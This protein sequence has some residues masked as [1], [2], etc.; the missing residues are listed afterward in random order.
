MPMSDDKKIICI[1]VDGVVLNWEDAFQVWMK[2]QG[3]EQVEGH[4]FIYDAAKQF[5]LTKGEGRKWVKLFNESAAMGFLPPLRDAQEILS[6]LNTNHGYRFVV[7]T[8]MST[9][10]N[11]TALRTRNLK[12]LF[13]DIFE[14]FIYLDT[15]ASKVEALEKMSR[16]YPGCF[17]VEDKVENAWAGSEKGFESIVMEHGYNMDDDHPFFVARDW[18]DIY[19]HITNRK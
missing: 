4:K 15:G 9:D 2:H 7:C 17:W 19:L 12:K 1:D 13:G 6:L 3:Y 16:K 14:E 5:D 8:S 18:E 11:A 10:K